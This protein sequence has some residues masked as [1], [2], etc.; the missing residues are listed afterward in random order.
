MSIITESTSSAGRNQRFHN[1]SQQTLEFC[2]PTVNTGKMSQTP[3][4]SFQVI[5]CPHICMCTQLFMS[6]IITEP[7]SSRSQSTMGHN[8]WQQT[9]EFCNPTV[10]AGKMS[11]TPTKFLQVICR[12]HICMCTQLFMSAIITEPTSST[13]QSTMGHNPWQQTVEFCDLTVNA[14]EMSQ[15][16]TKSLQVICRPHICMCTCC[17]FEEEG[18]RHRIAFNSLYLFSFKS[19]IYEANGEEL[20]NFTRGATLNWISTQYAVCRVSVILSVERSIVSGR[21]G[22]H[23]A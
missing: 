10:N 3:T 23:D 5:C 2:N 4:K 17:D 1:Q 18:R 20:Y 14:G 19:I 9:V 7:T 13:S 21:R 11:Q 15:T 16:P 6:A 8:P 12:P 22:L